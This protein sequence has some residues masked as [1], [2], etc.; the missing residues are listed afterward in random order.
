MTEA[1]PRPRRFTA[2]LAIVALVA[3]AIGIGLA[4][5]GLSE[6]GAS[7]RLAAAT[8][9]GRANCA[10]CHAREARL[11][12][13]S[14]HDLAM[15][16]ADSSTVLGN[17]SGAVV[18]ALW[19]HE[20][21]RATRGRLLRHHRWPRRQ[22]R[23]VSSGVHV[24]RL[25]APAVPG[26]VAGWPLSGAAAGLG[27]APE[28]RGRTALVSSLPQRAHSGRR[29]PALER[30]GAELELHVRGV[31]L[32]EPPQGLA[33]R[34]ER[35]RAIRPP[36]PRS[37]S[38]AKPATARARCT[39]PGRVARRATYAR[40]PHPLTAHQMGLQADLREPPAHWVMDAAPGIARRDRAAPF[41]AEIETCARCHSRRTELFEDYRA[42]RA[43]PA[44][45]QAGAARRSALLRRR[46]AARGSVRVRIVSAEPHA[47]CGSL[48][49]R[50]P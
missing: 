8:Y 18:H 50:L 4:L 26:R 2:A 13:G 24:R 45:A 46:A 38:R 23:R 43:A 25:S 37:T 35:L 33:L 28:G 7:E 11:Y 44:N 39:W 27:F 12:A 16:P 32:D 47:R 36:G 6:R 40:R 41:D 14:R 10:S 1:S 5:R 9:V 15:Q 30:P 21:V 22:S 31:P 34:F 3:P 48:V 20:P 17:F 29:H 19:R 49:R 42:G